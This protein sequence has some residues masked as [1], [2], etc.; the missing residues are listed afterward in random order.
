MSRHVRTDAHPKTRSETAGSADPPPSASARSRQNLSSDEERI[1][2]ELHRILTQVPAAVCITRGPTHVI[3][4]AN[5]LYQQMTGR[6]DLV[7]RTTR[8]AFPELATQG[9]FEL[10]DQVFTT[11]EPHTGTEVRVVWDRTGDG[12]LQ[13]GFVNHAYQPLTDQHGVVYGILLHIVD[14]TELVRSRRLI[15]GHADDLTRATQ[16]LTRINKELDQFA[17]VAS[18]DLKAPLRGIAS[19]A[20]WIEDDLGEKLSTENRKHLTLLRSRIERMDALIDGLLQYSRAGR[21]RNRVETV[22]VGQLSIEV[23]DM[24]SPAP[25][26]IIDIADDLPVFETEKLPLQQ[27]LL[28]LVSNSL[29]HSGRP[30]TSVRIAA[31]DNGE[32]FEFTV[33][34]NG[35]GIPR[36]FHNRVWEI[37]QTLQPR[38]KVEGAGIG[39]ALVKKNV[40]AR[41]GRAWL[42]STESEGTTVHFLW[43]KR[44]EEEG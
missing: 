22:D 10:L 3:E 19:L 29:K 9:F 40:E 20:Q 11:G 2:L 32:F 21:V 7:G 27:V 23:I 26:V 39:L 38:D 15:E 12:S 35:A 1:R 13:E 43:P 25:E 24:L 28:N 42:E 4:S 36:Q 8:E 44:L 17:Y 34:D 6:R 16:S 33:Q 5:L 30:D 41:G 31:H 18:H 14:V 37:F